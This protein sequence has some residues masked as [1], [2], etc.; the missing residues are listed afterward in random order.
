MA[1]KTS[2][3]FYITGIAEADTLLNRDGTALLIGMLLDQQV[4]MQWAFTGPYTIRQRLG[5]IDAKRIAEMDVDEFVTICRIKPAVHRFPNSMCKRVHALC[6]VIAM[7]YKGRGANV[8]AGVDDAEELFRR[9]HA[10]PGFGEEKSQIFVALLGKRFGVRPNGWQKVAG[11]FSDKQPRSVADINSPAALLKVRG[12]KKEQKV[13]NVDKQDR[14][15][16]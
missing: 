7:K 8:W 3:D 5:H 15:R 13:A 6:E 10:L 14:P 1:P 2:S 11:A 9:L 16:K 4:P 12:Y